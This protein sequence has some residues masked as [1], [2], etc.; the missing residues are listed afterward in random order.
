LLHLFSNGMLMAMHRQRY[1]CPTCLPAGRIL[2]H[3]KGADNMILQRI[4]PGQPLEASVR[5]H[6]DQMAAG[7]YRTL[8]VA[9][10]ELQVGCAVRLGAVQLV[11]WLKQWCRSRQ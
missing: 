2:L 4:A 7:G 5:Q 8:A 11:Q 10:R 9:Q 6:L 3:C 1:T